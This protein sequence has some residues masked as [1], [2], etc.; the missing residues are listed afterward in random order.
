MQAYGE[1]GGEDEGAQDDEEQEASIVKRI[2][3]LATMTNNLVNKDKE[4]Q[5]EKRTALSQ[6]SDSSLLD[7]FDLK[8]RDGGK[9][10]RK[11]HRK[12]S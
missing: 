6:L 7:K 12:I 2:N 11:T 5:Q 8:R 4:Q 1:E 9:H 10:D 3:D